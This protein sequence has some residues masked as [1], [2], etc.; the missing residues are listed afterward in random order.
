[1]TTIIIFAIALAIFGFMF[2]FYKAYMSVFFGWTFVGVFGFGMT[3][4]T[5]YLLSK[6]ET[7]EGLLFDKSE[8][9]ITTIGGVIIVALLAAWITVAVKALKWVLGHL[10]PTINKH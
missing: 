9:G 5:L 3:F 10:K 4:L 2:K 8:S 7:Y 6:S 1:M